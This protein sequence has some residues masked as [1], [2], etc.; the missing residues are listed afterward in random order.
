MKIV[1]YL[2]LIEIILLSIKILNSSILEQK[3]YSISGICVSMV[4]IVM[5]INLKKR[6]SR[7]SQ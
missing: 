1:F 4:V 6:L 5:V 7:Q 2:S 3:M